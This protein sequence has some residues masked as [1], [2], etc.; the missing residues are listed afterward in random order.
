MFVTNWSRRAGSLGRLGEGTLA[1]QDG[2]EEEL[3]PPP[4]SGLDVSHSC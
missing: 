1:R 4:L 2:A 3:H